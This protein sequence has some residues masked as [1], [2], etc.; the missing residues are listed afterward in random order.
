MSG[1]TERMVRE[2]VGKFFNKNEFAPGPRIVAEHFDISREEAEEL[3]RHTYTR[4]ER[5][6]LAT[7]QARIEAERM[8]A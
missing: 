2:Y 4:K 3:I 1:V 6:R 5:S 8:R 7:Q